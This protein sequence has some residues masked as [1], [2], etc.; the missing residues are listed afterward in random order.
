VGMGSYVSFR[1]T[2]VCLVFTPDRLV[3]GEL[4]ARIVRHKMPTLV[5]SPSVAAGLQVE[6][7]VA[8]SGTCNSLMDFG[9]QG[10]DGKPL[11]RNL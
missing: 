2:G 10:S 3:S 1:S 5:H 6:V 11:L 9:L 8:K 7:A 4:M